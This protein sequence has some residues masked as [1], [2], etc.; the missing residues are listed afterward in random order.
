MRG[1]PV[2]GSWLGWRWAWLAAGAG[3]VGLLAL[4][5]PAVAQAADPAPL[6]TVSD[7]NPNFSGVWVDTVNNELIV[8]DDNHHAAFVY[9]RTATGA[10]APLRTI[11]GLPT[12]LDYPSSLVVDTT[13]NELWA[14][15]DDTSDR[16]VVYSRT[17]NGAV[18]PLRV[19]DFK[20]LELTEKR[21]WGWSVDPLNN[22]VAGTFQNG[23]VVNFFGRA[24]GEPLRSIG[25]AS[26]G[27][28]DPHG[29]FIDSVNN[30]LF[31]VNEGH[32][33]G[34]PPQAPSITVFARTAS[35]NVA[36]LR[37]IQGASTGL[38][39][40]RPIHVDTVNSELA[41]AN[42]D[43]NSITVYSRTASGNVAPLRT[44]SGPTTGL[45]NPTGV[46]IDSVNNEIVVANWGNHSVTVYPRTQTGDGAPLRTI[47]A[48]AGAA[49][50]L[51]NPGAL[52]LDL[53]NGE[54]AVTNC[55]S[56][57]RIAFF[58]RLSNGQT[59]PLRLIEGQN[60]R[61]SRSLHGIAIDPVNNEVIVPSTLEDAI[62]VF[63]RTASGNVPPLRVIQ[64][65]L[66]GISKPQGIALDTVNNEIALANEATP[67]ITVYARAASGNAAPL[68]TITDPDGNLSK[69]VG[70]WIDN[71]NNE[72]V[73]AD[74]ADAT[75]RVIVYPRLANGPTTALRVITGAA[76]L[77]NKVRQVVVDT[78][79]NEI[80]VASQG[81]RD[82]NPPVFGD[83]AVFD[84]LANGNVAPKRFLQHV[85][86]SF[87]EH[88]RSVWVDAVNNEIGVG[89]SKLD[90]IRVFP[91]QF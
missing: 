77:L 13:N 90:E 7:P 50:G 74:G 49:T 41:V 71:V 9:S 23:S 85:T 57:P 11:K 5:L 67:S 24:T 36:P 21:T 60:T 79:N 86:T 43:A 42:G 12:L 38:S 61:I 91:R 59:G 2:V 10:A 55:V 29:I 34:A 63:G 6:R 27:L 87:V 56:H 81:N 68:R 54:F 18:A 84:R 88:P 39:L 4:L 16:A 72:I 65:A 89:D 83:V 82:V 64:G 78:T 62:L 17:A 20:A 51:G 19:V 76:T 73:V 26:T 52:S 47:T 32:V 14:V 30:E 22:E 15:N 80:V 35:G 37:T 1:V 70:V 44:I 33:F 75:D 69:P 28:A 40:P 45:S 58:P 31:V 53:V 25:G 8:G 3:V 48:G 46:F 66:T